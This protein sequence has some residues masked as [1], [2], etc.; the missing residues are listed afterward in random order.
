MKTDKASPAPFGGAPNRER[1]FQAAGRDLR[2]FLVAG[3]HSGDALGAKLMAALNAARRGRIRYVGVGGAAM[4]ALG[5]ISQFPM[6]E[7]AVMG[8]GA[9]VRR[10]PV[11]LSRITTT[12]AA[13]IAADPDALIIIDSPEF[14]HRI[15]RRVRRRRPDI[16][17]LNYVSPSVWAWRPG[18]AAKMR[19][20]IDHVLALLPFEPAAHRALGGPPCSYVGHPLLERLEWLRALD[21]LPLARR[22][23]LPPGSEVLAVLPGSRASEV[24]RLMGPFGEAVRRLLAEGRNIEVV[25][26]VVASVRTMVEE[27]AL[28]W[29]KRPHLVSSEEDKFSALK[30]ARA[31]LAAS[32]TVTLELA[33]A[34][35]PM[36]VG[37]KVDAMAGRVLRRLITAPSVVLVNLVLGERAIPELLQEHC[38][39]VELAAALASIL[40]EGP[41]RARQLQALARVPQR[42]AVP[43][44]SPSEA[45]ADIVLDYAEYGRGWP[46][47]ERASKA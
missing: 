29:P 8:P 5:L 35:T 30:L 44:G 24:G 32:G 25:T 47:P 11:I 38:T 43:K 6:E 39:P 4:E 40:E 34:G 14:T 2:L 31:A 9:I 20:Y 46:R 21:T 36:V 17:I 26:P 10:L 18:R 37:Y 23:A 16:P 45:A 13:V 3:E 33:L 27:A 28:G 12:A 1:R 15:A 22:L 19:D 7:V 42:M 41:P